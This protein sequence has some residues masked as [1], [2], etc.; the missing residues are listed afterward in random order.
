MKNCG[1]RNDIENRW[2]GVLVRRAVLLLLLVHIGG[3]A[4][5]ELDFGQAEAL[6]KTGKAA[7]AFALLDPFEDQYA[8]NVRY[9]YLLGI[10]ALDSGKPDRATLAF[11]R[12]L[13]VDP[14][15]AGARLDMARAYFQLG[16]L[17]RAKSE[18]ETVLAQNPPEAARV[19]IAR[20]LDAIA[21][22]EKAKQTVLRGYLEATLGHDDNVNNS[23]SQSQI[24]V[25]ALGNLIFTLDPTNVKRA[26]SY[27][28]FGAGGDVSHEINP[29]FAVFGGVDVRY[30]SNFSEDRFDY[31][32]AD[33]R[34]GAAFLRDQDVFRVSVGGGRYYLD[35]ASNRDTTGFMADWRRVLDPSNHLNV[36]AQHSRFRFAGATLS[37]NDFDQTILGAGWLRVLADGKSAYSA[38]LFG[39]E[40]RDTNNR[41]DGGK[42][43]F[44]VRFGGQLGVRDNVDLFGSIGAQRGDYDRQNAAFQ[45]TRD[46]EQV[47]ATLGLTWRLPNSWTVRPQLMY[48]RN[49][50]NIPIYAYE[51]TDVSI[52]LRRDFP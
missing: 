50:S 43:L 44:G 19:T 25:P 36:F 12:V 33:A 8:G 27:A 5:A 40:E 52:T 51:R 31:K 15:F 6:V 2:V 32:S 1:I 30:R 14:N 24:A 26:D 7:E 45:T 10:A 16:D 17:A 3:V 39:G 38:A 11:E 48:V 20:Y 28:L 9:D 29:A 4:A 49:R 42:R 34:V 18:F 46:D 23:T 35:H 22:R 13:A 41:A 21:Q 47:D 37:V